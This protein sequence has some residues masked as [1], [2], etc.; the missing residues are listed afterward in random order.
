MWMKGDVSLQQRISVSGGAYNERGFGTSAR[1]NARLE[2][3]WT[4]K[5]DITLTDG[6]EV[7][8]HAYDGTREPSET[9]YLALNLP[10]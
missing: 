7:A 4:F 9:G 8:S 5:H 10:F 1:W 2:H 3:A 6:I